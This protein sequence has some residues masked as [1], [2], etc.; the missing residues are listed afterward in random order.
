MF[1]TL[2]ISILDFPVEILNVILIFLVDPDYMVLAP[3]SLPGGGNRID[4]DLCLGHS[5]ILAPTDGNEMLVFHGKQQPLKL[6][7]VIVIK[8]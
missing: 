1:F 8:F 2:R 4:L 6:L 5:A 7:S 3:G